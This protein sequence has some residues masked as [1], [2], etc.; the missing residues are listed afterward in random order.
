MTDPHDPLD[1]G[2]APFAALRLPATPLAP[3]P[4]FADELR[5]RLEARL[6]PTPPPTT[7]EA[8]TV[9]T[10]EPLTA[11]APSPLVPYLSVAGAAE[12]LDWY[13]DVFGAIETTRFVGDDGRVGHA[14]IAIGTARLYL[15]DEFPEMGVTGPITQGGTTVALHLEVAEVDHTYERAV[16]AGATALR[17]PADQGHG[18]RNATITDPFGHRWMLSQPI[19]AARTE[20][21][22]EEKGAGGDGSDWTVSGRQP[23]EPGY[24]VLHTADL[25]RARAFFSALFD[26]EIETGGAGGG[27]VGNTRF[28]LG[29]A[30]PGDDSA[31]RL[32]SASATT[33]YFRVDD[34]DLYAQRVV[35]LGG[36]VLARNAYDSGGN[37]ECADD[38][39]Y[40]FD[41]W[42]P[43]PG[44]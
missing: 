24:L 29:I 35:D 27:H 42:L 1:H 36:Q 13:R 21:A 38:Q 40:R 4:G 28:P 22:L 19:D 5:R 31:E 8:P 17:P 25:S 33:V 14:E 10:T 26:W 16:A 9:S 2:E 32:D 11:P 34:L 6:S 39:G 15:A 41:L 18:N 3:R 23:V 7:Q 44:Y 12:A 37:V 30:P 20:V 43:A